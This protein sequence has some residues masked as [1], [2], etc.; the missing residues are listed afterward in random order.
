MGCWGITAFESDE[1]LD[2]VEFI[3]ES[4]PEDGKL[5][6]EALLEALKQDS[7]NA[8]PEVET[9]GSHTSVMALAELMLKFVNGKVKSLDYDG[10]WGKEDHK[11]DSI[12]SFTAHRDTIQWIRNYIFD[13]LLNVKKHAIFQAEN[14]EKW[15]GWFE[16]KNW[17]GW[18]EHMAEL[19]SRLDI[20]LEPSEAVIELIPLQSPED[21]EMENSREAERPLQ[22]Q[23]GL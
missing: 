19:V 23:L 4:L 9:A 1:G 3:R 5:E 15:G 11:F 16:E 17:I 20:L 2:A 13:T 18:Q 14:G 22:N 10:E 8:P 7:W 21:Q 6:L 12:T